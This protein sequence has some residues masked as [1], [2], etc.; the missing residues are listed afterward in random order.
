MSFKE[1]LKKV[2]PAILLVVVVLVIVKVFGVKPLSYW[3]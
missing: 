2:I 3:W 1:Y